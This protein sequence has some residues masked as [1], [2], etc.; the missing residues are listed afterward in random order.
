MRKNLQLLFLGVFLLAATFTFTAFTSAAPSAHAASLTPSVAASTCPRT[1]QE[2]DKGPDKGPAVKLAQQSLNWFYKHT[3]FKDWVNSNFP[4]ELPIAEDGDF[5]PHTFDAVLDFQ[6]WD[7]GAHLTI[8]GIV[9]PK[10]WHALG[11]C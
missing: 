7:T 6:A 10:T 1:V 3:N 5:G 9:G 11:H 8:D 2:G 4:G